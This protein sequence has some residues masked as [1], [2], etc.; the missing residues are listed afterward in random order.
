VLAAAT[1]MPNDYKAMVLEGSSTGKPF[2]A[3]GTTSWP[4]QCSFGI[5]AV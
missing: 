3:D 5:C 4:A 1:A 2:A